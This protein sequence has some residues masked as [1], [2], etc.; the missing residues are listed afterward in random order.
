[1]NLA[2]TPVKP[3]PPRNRRQTVARWLVGAT[4]LLVLALI[5]RTILIQRMML[6]R[7]TLPYNG[8]V[9]TVSLSPDGRTLFAGGDPSYST[10]HW[11]HNP[12]ADVFIW[13]SSSGKLLRRLHG[14]FWRS[15]ATTAAPDGRH[16]VAY[17]LTTPNL[18]QNMPDDFVVVWDWRTGQQVRKSDGMYPIAFSPDGRLMSAG[19]GVY[20]AAT[21]KLVCRTTHHLEEE[22]PC[23]FTPD[24]KAVGLI[25]AQTTNTASGELPD[26][27]VVYAGNFLR[28]WRADNGAHVRDFPFIRAR[29]YDFS[30]DGKWLVLSCDRGQMINGE[31][32]SIVR[33]IDMATGKVLWTRERDMS[34][35][36]HDEDAIV[37]SVAISPS[38]KYVVLQSEENRLIVLDAQTGRELFRPLV[39]HRRDEPMWSLTG[40]VAF[41]ADGKTLASRNGHNVLVWDARMLE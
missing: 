6:P 34:D 19:N 38:G 3:A 25:D 29:C 15:Y 39:Y 12:P 23:A 8:I 10:L 22:G 26:V 9:M 32:G 7:L 20:D 36:D 4:C 16:V 37:N 28:L 13:D 14:L 18:V 40:G 31:D 17:G 1:M 27:N 33:R 11:H 21:G 41:S 2:D 30:R 24:G 5:A 35:P